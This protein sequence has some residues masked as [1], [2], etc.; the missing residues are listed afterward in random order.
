M[1]HC[2]SEIIALIDLIRNRE[3]IGPRSRTCFYLYIRQRSQDTALPSS[4]TDIAQSDNLA[5][6]SG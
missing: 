5:F 1:F 2:L 4:T 6:R 3:T